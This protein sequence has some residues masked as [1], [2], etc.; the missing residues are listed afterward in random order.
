[1]V[2]T[3]PFENA[4]MSLIQPRARVTAGTRARANRNRLQRASMLR[5]R[6]LRAHCEISGTERFNYPCTLI[7]SRP[8][9]Y[10]FNHLLNYVLP[11][12]ILATIGIIQIMAQ[13]KCRIIFSSTAERTM[14]RPN[15]QSCANRRYRASVSS[16]QFVHCL[17]LAATST[18]PTVLM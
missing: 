3:N 12:N 16:Q 17:A 6:V 9:L 13:I 10:K 15:P 4:P 7:R 14:R 2:F 5:K 18:R 1:M 8:F 11:Q